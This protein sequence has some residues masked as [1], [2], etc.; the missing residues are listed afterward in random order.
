VIDHNSEESEKINSY[1]SNNVL[2]ENYN[3]KDEVGIREK[4]YLS[5]SFKREKVNK[6][7]GFKEILLNMN[8]LY[9]DTKKWFKFKKFKRKYKKE[10]SKYSGINKE[11]V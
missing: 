6:K 10:E 3:L 4:L 7:P 5:S 1:Y 9:K 8:I 11:L 2:N